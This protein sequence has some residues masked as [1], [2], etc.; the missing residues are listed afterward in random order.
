MPRLPN[1]R[2][3]P[4]TL[5]SIGTPRLTL[6]SLN[7][8]I[9]PSSAVPPSGTLTVVCTVVTLNVGS[10]T[11]MFCCAAAWP[12]AHATNIPLAMTERMDMTG[13][14]KGAFPFPS[15]LNVSDVRR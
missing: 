12:T 9:P 3:T 4:G 13:L 6:P 15:F 8:P 10:W 5:F 11:V 2:L 7:R 14:R 1:S